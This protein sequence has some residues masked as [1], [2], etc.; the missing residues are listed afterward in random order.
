MSNH[1]VIYGYTITD[2][3]SFNDERMRVTA[4]SIETSSAKQLS[5]IQ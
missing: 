3:A 2:D 1:I 4:V 5:S